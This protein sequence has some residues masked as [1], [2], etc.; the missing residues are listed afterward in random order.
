MGRLVYYGKDFGFGVDAWK[1][2][3]VATIGS[4]LLY[5]SG[6]GEGFKDGNSYSKQ[7]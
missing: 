2:L 1:V 3:A 5:L 4:T 7:D 6:Y